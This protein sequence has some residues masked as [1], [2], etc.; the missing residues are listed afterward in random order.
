M[1]FVVAVLVSYGAALIG[2]LWLPARTRFGLIVLTG[3][4][5]AWATT[6]LAGVVTSLVLGRPVLAGL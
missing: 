1:L 6:L 5:I 2:V 4:S 3:L